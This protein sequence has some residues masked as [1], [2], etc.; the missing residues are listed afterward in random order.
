LKTPSWHFK[1]EPFEK[2]RETHERNLQLAR[3]GSFEPFVLLCLARVYTARQRHG[4][5]I[6]HYLRLIEL[7][8][9]L[10]GIASIE[11]GVSSCLKGD[12]REAIRYLKEAVTFLE[13]QSQERPEE[14][15]RRLVGETY[16]GFW[17]GGD[18]RLN[19][20]CHAHTWLA[21]L[22]ME[23]QEEEVARMHLGEATD[24]LNRKELASVRHV[25]VEELFRLAE[26]QFP[27]LAEE[28]SLRGLRGKTR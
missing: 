24:Y 6:A 1:T 7:E 18:E 13:D 2:V 25:L 8:P 21:G 22:F 9:R 20:L 5:A 10:T 12:L 15:T 27:R 4:E 23:N 14:Y 28:T 16:G 3:G 19:Q 26:T 11:M 17:E